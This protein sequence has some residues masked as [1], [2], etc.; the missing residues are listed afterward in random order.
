MYDKCQRYSQIKNDISLIDKIPNKEELVKFAEWKK[1]VTKHRLADGIFYGILISFFALG[2]MLPVL[3]AVDI[4]GESIYFCAVPIL[5]FYI[6]G[7][8]IC[9]KG[10]LRA[11]SWEIDYCKTGK[12]HDKY[13]IRITRSE[14]KFYI[15]VLANDELLKIR[16]KG[17]DYSSLKINDDVIVFS[18]KGE[19]LDVMKK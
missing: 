9:I 19:D 14:T 12:V 18:I 16:T 6:W 17:G 10:Y 7:V 15:I 3:W 1:H 2:M 8:T 13:S 11:Q 5:I 4:V